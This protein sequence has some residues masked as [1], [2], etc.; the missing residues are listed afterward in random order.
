MGAEYYLLMEVFRNCPT[1]KHALAY[2]EELSCLH[3]ELHW[4]LDGFELFFPYC[5]DYD[6]PESALR[7][8]RQKFLV[9]RTDDD[10][11]YRIYDYQEK[12]YQL[13][14][15][16]LCIGLNEREEKMRE[17]IR[18]WLAQEGEQRILDRLQFFQTHEA[19][20][21]MLL[22][23]AALTHRRAIPDVEELGRSQRLRDW[24][25]WNPDT[26]LFEGKD[27][28][29]VAMMTFVVE[30]HFRR[31]YERLCDIKENLSEFA[32]GLADDI[33]AA[34]LQRRVRGGDIT[35]DVQGAQPPP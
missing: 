9:A 20:R 27:E 21:Q 1:T 31:V 34:F 19:I 26:D 11:C 22:R 16:A 33:L 7:L 15:A 10:F 35:G 5:A 14:N 32:N 24:L 28:A 30:E 23:R 13:L 25:R 29:D 18:T 2:A 3:D 12:C 6:P 17:K 8:I 4:I